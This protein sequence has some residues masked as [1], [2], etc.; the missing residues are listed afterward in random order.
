MQNLKNNIVQSIRA[1][2][3]SSLRDFAV[4]SGQHFLYADLTQAQN[5]A[6]VLETL[7][8]QFF[9]P[10]YCA[11]SLDLLQEALTDSLH[12]MAKQPG[13][14]VVLN[15]IPCGTKLDRESREQLLDMFRDISD[16]WADKKISF[17]CFYSFKLALLPQLEPVMPPRDIEDEIIEFG[18]PLPTDKVTDVS[19]LALRM[20]NPFNP[21]YW[22]IP[23]SLQ[24]T[25]EANA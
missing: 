22:Q 6:E 5:W 18:E 15:H 25:L 2:K 11:K 10:N 13:F 4:G 21:L 16:Y 12:S 24:S 20:S 8:I 17:R 3:P 7:S 9:L 19:P 23:A 14:V 1:L